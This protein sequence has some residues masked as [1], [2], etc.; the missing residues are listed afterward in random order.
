MARHSETPLPLPTRIAV[1]LE[2]DARLDRAT[3]LAAKVTAPLGRG[4]AASVLSGRWFGHALHPAL[5]DVPVGLFTA[6]GALDALGG[7]RSRDAAQRLLGLGL[8]AAAP[9]AASGWTEWHAA[10][11]RDRR[12]GVVHAALN[13]ASLAAYTGSWLTRRRGQHTSGVALALVGSGLA[14]AAAYLGGHLAGARGVA[15][16]HPALTQRNEQMT[17]PRPAPEPTTAHDVIEAITAQHGEITR[18]VAAVHAADQAGRPDALRRLLAYLAGHE[19]VEE[20]LLH[21]RAGTTADPDAGAERIAEEEGV[22][23]QIRRLEDTGTDSPV[24]LTQF[25][26]IEE[27]I[28]QH[29]RAE[30]ERELP[31]LLED[32][33][34]TDAALVVQALRQQASAAEHRTG[35]FSDMLQTATHDVRGLAAR[36]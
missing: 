5:T 23:Q 28:T 1:A 34:A 21:P 11:Q 14:G 7:V 8:L 2:D 16:R 22:G 6:A 12:V 26:L 17:D 19:A 18:L 9:T 3:A 24:F 10:S 25:G 15:T 31:V 30:E 29:A 35:S 32:L 33:G 27:A 20:V 36:G 4:A 13:A